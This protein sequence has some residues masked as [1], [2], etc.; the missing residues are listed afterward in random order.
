M[1]KINTVNKWES[2][3]LIIESIEGLCLFNLTLLHY[4]SVIKLIE[5]MLRSGNLVVRN[6]ASIF[7]KSDE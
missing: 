7:C 4:L 5:T 1:Q 2:A 3:K 6:T